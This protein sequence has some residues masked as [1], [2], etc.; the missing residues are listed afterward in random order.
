MSHIRQ[1]EK[2]PVGPGRPFRAEIILPYRAEG[3][4]GAKERDLTWCR[5]QSRPALR[6]RVAD[7]RCITGRVSMSCP[8]I[9]LSVLSVLVRSITTCP[10][11]MPPNVRDRDAHADAWDDLRRWLRPPGS[12][13]IR[14]SRIRCEPS[15]RSAVRPR[16]PPGRLRRC[17]AARCGPD[18]PAAI[19]AHGMTCWARACSP[20]PWCPSPTRSRAPR[21]PPSLWRYKSWRAPSAAARTSMLALLLAFLHDHGACVW[22]QRGHARARAGWPWCRPAAAARDRTR[23]SRCPLPTCGC[24]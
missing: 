7:V 3:P 14:S 6:A 11:R 15:H 5:H 8:G 12:R 23:C 10:D 9:T 13:C 4:G 1:R 21:S 2:P 18:S 19:N 20:T 17:A 22:R 16:P 24:R